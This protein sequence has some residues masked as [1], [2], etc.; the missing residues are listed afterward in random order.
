M[1]QTLLFRQSLFLYFY[2]MKRLYIV[3]HG[4]SSRDDFS[5]SDHDRPVTEKGK[6]KTKK[7]AAALKAKGVLPDLIVSSTAKRA[8]ETAL[9]LAHELDYPEDKIVFS[10]TIYHAYDVSLLE[11]LYGIDDAVESVMVVGHNP[12]LTDVVNIFA[13]EMIDN[14][15]TSAVAAIH[16][17]TKHWEQIDTCRY[18]L[19]YILTPKMLRD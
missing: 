9:L 17:K 11:E 2:A 3:R 19:D 10:E 18:K 14:L 13:K 12:T 4:K 16:F 7:I 15:P 5:I 1:T 6:Q 8:K